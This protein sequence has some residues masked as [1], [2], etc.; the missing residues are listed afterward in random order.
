MKLSPRLASASTGLW[1]SISATQL[2][3]AVMLSF[4]A[5]L[6]QKKLGI[7]AVQ[8]TIFFL[9]ALSRRLKIRL[10]PSLFMI[11]GITFFALFSPQ[12]QVLVRLG[13]FAITRGALESGLRRGISLA[14]MVFLSQL[15]V[16][17]GI[18]LPGKIGNFVVKIFTL[19]DK[20]A[21]DPLIDSPQKSPGDKGKWKF[22]TIKNLVPLL[23]QRLYQ[24]YW[25]WCTYEDTGE[26]IPTEKKS[27]KNKVLGG[28]FVV[29]F[30]SLLYFFLFIK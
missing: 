4:P 28:V 24:V 15:A 21:K 19:L 26:K 25:N 22:E 30:P 12:G 20:L 18:K 3:V 17:P 10:L 14:G 13:N 8:A 2:F 29:L 23:D 11:T 9:L 1:S 7:L 5:F 16:A 27:N 6:F